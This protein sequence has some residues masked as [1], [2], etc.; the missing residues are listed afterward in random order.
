MAK[1]FLGRDKIPNILLEK[2]D[3][4]TIW[5]KDGVQNKKWVLEVSD[6]SWAPK[7][8]NGD[9]QRE[10]VQASSLGNGNKLPF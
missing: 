8:S 7:A 10:P 1:A 4:N 3:H 2:F 6:W 5:E 9:G